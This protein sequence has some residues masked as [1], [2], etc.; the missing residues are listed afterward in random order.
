VQRDLVAA[1]G[2]DLDVVAAT[3]AADRLRDALTGM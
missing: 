3:V 2:L 1:E